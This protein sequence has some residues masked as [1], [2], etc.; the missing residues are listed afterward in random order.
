MCLL[1]TIRGWCGFIARSD[2]PLYTNR[3]KI[4]HFIALPFLCIHPP[5]LTP[6]FPQPLLSLTSCCILAASCS[7]NACFHFQICKRKSSRVVDIISP[8]EQ[9]T[10]CLSVSGF[11][12]L[13]S[14]GL[15]CLC[16][17]RSAL[18]PTRIIGNSSLSFTRR[19]CLWNL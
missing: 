15:T 6:P 18:F 17:S 7:C 9:D 10:L 14:V 12:S 3:Q 11:R 5:L 2:K 1:C 16:S 19:I 8:D 4:H 13:Q